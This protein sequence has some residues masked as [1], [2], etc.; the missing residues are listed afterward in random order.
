MD[1]MLQPS[2]KAACS[3][4]FDTR[5][6]PCVAWLLVAEAEQEQPTARLQ[7]RR[8]PFDV[9]PPVLVAEDVEQ[10]AVD[11]VVEPLGP[12]LQRQGVHD[13]KRGRHAPLG[14]LPLR[15]LD[16]LVEEVDARD[17]AASAGEEEGVV[18]GAAT[19]VE[20]GA[21]DPVGHVD[22]RLL[23]PADVPGRLA[24]VERLEGAA[25]GDHGG[26]PDGQAVAILSS[27]AG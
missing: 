2:A 6:G 12:V 22:E 20:D 5:L 23:R 26:S 13:Q 8:Q 27:W 19:G 25:V 14:C 11:H 1:S 21:G 9:A 7:D 18:A 16:R 3:S 4:F 17:L 10:A 24:G 15:P